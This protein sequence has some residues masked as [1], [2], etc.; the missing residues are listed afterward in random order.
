M[1]VL[2]DSTDSEWIKPDKLEVMEKWCNLENILDNVWIK[3]I[4]SYYFKGQRFREHNIPYNV[5]WIVRKVIGA[6]DKL[7]LLDAIVGTRINIIKKAYMQFIRNI[8][9]V[10]WKYFICH[11]NAWP[12]V[13]IT[14]WLQEK[15]ILLTVDR[16]LK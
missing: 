16:L 8:P 12:K 15:N 13:V 4:H 7:H 10:S 2:G 5:S 1:C 6:K 11:N 9:K 14:I 3:W